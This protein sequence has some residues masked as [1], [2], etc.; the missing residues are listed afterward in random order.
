MLYSRN[1]NRFFKNQKLEILIV[2]LIIFSI[3]F[4]LLSIFNYRNS[5]LDL[6]NY[7]FSIIFSIELILRCFTFK[8]FLD[9]IK[10]FSLDWISVIPWELFLEMC[11]DSNID[12]T[13]MKFFRLFR[14]L[15]IL[16]FVTVFKTSLKQKF[17]YLAIKQL[18]KTVLHQLIV[19]ITFN[20]LL[21]VAFGIIFHFLGIKLEQGN[22]F[23]FSILSLLG[24]DGLYTI[25]QAT[26]F[27]K[28][29]T[30]VL[31]LLGVIFFN[32]VLIA[33]IITKIQ[34]YLF[35][36]SKGKGTVIEKNHYV[37]LGWNDSISY[38]IEQLNLY[39]TSE[40]KDLTIVI[41]TE[42]IQE[43]LMDT[44]RE[45]KN[46]DVIYRTGEP[47]NIKNLKNISI[48][49][50]KGVIIFSNSIRHND[51]DILD[52]EMI[53]TFI[54]FIA[55]F[56]DDLSIPSAILN[57]HDFSNRRFIKHIANNS[58]FFFNKHFYIAK[59]ISMM[60]TNIE[61]YHIFAELMSFRG[62]EF[63]FVNID[64]L[65]GKCFGE[66]LCSF[67]NAI[68]IGYLRNERVELLPREEEKIIA[69]D[70]IVF[71]A[72]N[73]DSISYRKK[74]FPPIKGISENY[75][76]VKKNEDATFKK[77]LIFGMNDRLPFII[78]EFTKME[79]FCTIVS[80]ISKTDFFKWFYVEK[81]Q[82]NRKYLKYV[83]CDF[84][85]E[86]KLL[87]LLEKNQ[88]S[89]CILLSDEYNEE[90]S[91]VNVIDSNTFYQLL[92]LLY[93]EKENHLDLNI[94]IELLNPDNVG[95]VKKIQ[96]D[97]SMKDC[98]SGCFFDYVVGTKM[99]AEILCHILINPYL[100]KIY[101]QIVQIGDVDINIRILSTI[102]DNFE[103]QIQF[104]SVLIDLYQELGIIVIG[105]IENGN[106]EPKLNPPKDTVL[107][108]TDQIIYL[109]KSYYNNE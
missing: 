46:I 68:P 33:I 5:N 92:Q 50:C 72:T 94:I 98:E 106:V 14:L 39:S 80:S 27:T 59:I 36:I 93:T 73:E 3:I 47:F 32:G 81:K 97:H 82:N 45:N 53:K 20:I 9:Y 89:F 15:K 28:F 99:I 22:P 24:P 58:S 29:I 43:E 35:L 17:I 62:N 100:I 55:C 4:A 42:T 16:R 79:V 108:S 37:I 104:G 8:K 34:S 75:S 49:Q 51:Q 105:Y 107:S 61:Y 76:L 57:F 12:L 71:L 65:Q 54:S 85:E 102:Y 77:V 83:Q 84:S 31:T 38:I 95:I 109:E 63:H 21:S 1:L 48:D 70:S 41:L 40:K 60:L 64:H 101:N 30:L 25:P 13:Y 78:E 87:N 66:F 103:S 67:Q 7:S 26:L 11:V 56:Q 2:I 23:W 69:G 44:V 74:T 6:I 86:K 91:D 52:S 18:Q 96:Y 90:S 10:N 19:L 88:L